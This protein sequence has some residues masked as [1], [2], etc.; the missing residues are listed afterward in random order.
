MC[1]IVLSLIWQLLKTKYDREERL[2]FASRKNSLLV[3]SGM[4]D[5]MSLPDSN[6]FNHGGFNILGA[7]KDVAH[8]SSFWT[9]DSHTE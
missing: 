8:F 4:Q 2:L 5:T 7:K 9:I 6:N 1:V 3:L